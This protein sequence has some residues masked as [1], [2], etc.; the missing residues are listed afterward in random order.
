MIKNDYLE[1]KMKKTI[2]LVMSLLLLFSLAAPAFAAGEDAAER[3]FTYLRAQDYE[4]AMKSFMEADQ[5]GNT[6]GAFPVGEMYEFGN[7]VKK[8][9]VTAVKWY[10][11]AS[12]AGDKQAEE[13]LKQ[14]PMK[15]IAE[16]MSVQE[17]ATHVPG[18]YGD[19]E[20]VRG[21]TYPFYPDFPVIGTPDITIL[22]QFIEWL[23]GWPYGN[24]YIYVR[25]VNGHWHHT[26]MIRLDKSFKEG[27]TI[28][29]HVDFDKPETFTAI[30]LCP[31][32]KGMDYTVLFNTLF[33]VSEEHVGKY[34]A[35]IPRPRFT[36]AES[37]NPVSFTH[38]ETQAYNPEDS[39]GFFGLPNIPV[40]GSDKEMHPG[41]CF[42]AG[43]QVCAEN[44]LVPIEEIRAGDL[45]WSWNDA[46][47][48][49]ELKPVVDTYVNPCHELTHLT[50]CGETITC[51]PQH[52]FYVP[53]KGW[54]R[55]GEL[56]V[57]DELVLLNGEIVN[58]EGIRYEQFETPVTVY[59]FQVQDTHSYYVGE[60]GIRVHNANE[61]TTGGEG[62]EIS[63]PLC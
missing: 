59:N 17:Q 44:G 42:V 26:A 34:S 31:A 16:A 37:E 40:T 4:N 60:A 39:D 51:T 5:A 8:D 1:E 48:T 43:T 18:L 14:E 49:A 15:S 57:G 11:K 45:V 53:Q 10:I 21:P 20:G 61:G 47:D 25:D 24:H 35:K 12:K 23:G 13:K 54:T 41:V 27:D 62:Y 3:G 63:G 55:A 32:D 30:A 46:T 33:F 38:T 58:V 19:V 36:P 29:L 22:I 28:V 2:A 9:L 7:G 52:R 56:C 50:V 6:D